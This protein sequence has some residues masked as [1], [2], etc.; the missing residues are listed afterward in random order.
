MT[1][2]QQKIQ[3]LKKQRD[4]ELLKKATALFTMDNQNTL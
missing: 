2:E 4:N 3:S 1:P